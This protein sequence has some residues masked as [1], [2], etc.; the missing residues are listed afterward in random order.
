MPIRACVGT[1]KLMYLLRSLPPQIFSPSISDMEALLR[2][3][4]ER[5]LVERCPSF[6]L[7]QFQLATLP[8][9]HSGLGI[10]KPA[11]ISKLAYIASLNLTKHLQDQILHLSAEEEAPFPR[12]FVVALHC[13]LT[14]TQSENN[15]LP[16][17]TQSSLAAYFITEDVLKFSPLNTSCLNLSSYN[18]AFWRSYNPLSNVMHLLICL[19]CPTL[20]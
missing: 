3:T 15:E 4:L 17:L 11:D 8:I 14:Y 12:K 1:P 13:F 5:I 16:H 6:G 19:H 18:A 20:A 2:S 7:F 9:S 10:Y